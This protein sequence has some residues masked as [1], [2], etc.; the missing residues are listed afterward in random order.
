MLRGDQVFVGGSSGAELGLEGVLK[1]QP[2]LGLLG[3]G[4]PLQGIVVQLREALAAVLLH[5]Q[6]YT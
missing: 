1:G 6:V 3:L 5:T 2:G 4:M